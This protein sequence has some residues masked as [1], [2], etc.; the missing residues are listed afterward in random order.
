LATPSKRLSVWQ[1]GLPEADA[2][3]IE[4]ALVANHL[5]VQ[6]DPAVTADSILAALG[7]DKKVSAD[8]QNRWVLLKQLGRAESGILVASELVSRA[9]ELLKTKP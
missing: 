7:N 3:R 8:G 9:V 4:A 1:A 2:R 6:L 5:P